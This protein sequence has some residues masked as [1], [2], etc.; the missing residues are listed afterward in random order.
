MYHREGGISEIL[1]YQNDVLN[2]TWVQY[3]TDGTLKL[4]ANHVEG[5]LHGPATYFYNTGVIKAK[6]S[7]VKG[8]KDRKWEFFT[9]ESQL[10]KTETY[11]NGEILSTEI[12]IETPPEEQE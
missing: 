11:Q 8:F 4:E 3:F 5:A 6:G 1:H 10:Q 7:Y 2:G 12:F 9:R